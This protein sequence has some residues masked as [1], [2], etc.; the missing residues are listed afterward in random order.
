M[1]TEAVI[2][3][4]ALIQPISEDKPQ[5]EDI[6][7]DYS[8][9]S[10]YYQIKDARS[11]AR[12]AER[13]RLTHQEDDPEALL[14]MVPEWNKVLT[15]APQILTQNGK[16]LEVAA[17]YCEALL[18]AYAFPGLR[19]GFKLIHA[20]VENF[21][22][23]LY[24]MP[25]EDGMETRVAPLT[26]LNGE[27][28]EGTLIVPIR[29]VPL[30]EGY[31]DLPF[32][33]W[34]YEQAYEVETIQD[35]EKKE[36]RLASGAVSMQAIERAVTE[37]SPA[38]FIQLKEDLQECLDDFL[39]LSNSLDEK[40]GHDS[41]PSSNIR[42]T[43][44]RIIEIF[45]FMTKNVNLEPEAPAEEV[46]LEEEGADGEVTATKTVTKTV[47][48]DNVSISSR[49]EAFRA[50][51]KVSDFFKSTEPHSPISYNLEQAVKWGHMSL[52]D[53]LKE[54]IPDEHART[55]YFKLVGIKDQEE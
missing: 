4:D 17:W 32:A 29:Q 49:D 3:I 45:G 9:D 50:L 20:L 42:N 26:G 6:R 13:Q 28:G 47:T 27:D 34:Q 30:T 19:D 55:E 10:V 33:A 52:P 2:D 14:Q 48:I 23:D 31:T 18:R 7:E 22:D 12:T 5:G 46:E 54:L 16:D 38:F 8:P 25:D 40:C 1:A 41:P 35:P 51:M 43:L 24:P 21:W 44:K 53:L 37:T 36:A 11:E 39:A 15:L